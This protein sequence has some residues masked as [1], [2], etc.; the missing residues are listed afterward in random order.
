MDTDCGNTRTQP[1]V[2]QGFT[3]EKNF[4]AQQNQTC[5][6]TWFPQKNVHRCRSTHC[7]QQAGQ[8]P[9]EIDGLIEALDHWASIYFKKT[10]G[11]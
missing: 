1:N 4:P 2:K 9:Q 8:R 11:S 10:K 5:Q 6:K 7:E 3:D